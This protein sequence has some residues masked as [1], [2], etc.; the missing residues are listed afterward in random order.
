MVDK[1][2]LV[3]LGNP[4]P[5]ALVLEAL[6]DDGREVIRV[7]TAPDKRRGRGGATSPTDVKK[8]AEEY[9]IP[10][11][12][13]LSWFSEPGASRARGIV[14]AYGR[15][16]PKSVLDIVP[17]WNV[18]FSLLPR[19]RGA[20]PVARAILAGDTVTG[21]SIM[22]LEET[23]DTGG[24]LRSESV[25]IGDRDTTDSLTLKLAAM[26]ARLLLEALDD[27]NLALEP[28]IGDPVYAHKID[29]AELR[30]RWEETARNV[31]RQIRALRAYTHS[32]GKR[33][34]ILETRPCSGGPHRDGGPG[35]VMD[36]GCVRTGDGFLGLS[37]VQM[38]GRRSQTMGEWL[39]GVRGSMPVLGDR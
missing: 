16:I 38:E 31:D 24:I 37:L 19:W 13:D 36:D 9:G 27:P 22:E 28:Q 26:G 33:M 15:L 11:G 18:H 32:G 12:H 29:P 21:V 4:K 39:S 3:F 17:M 25:M 14:V 7:V 34:R 1:Q 6:L 5:A 30:I 10:V 8:I 23:L 35:T 2:P 20:A